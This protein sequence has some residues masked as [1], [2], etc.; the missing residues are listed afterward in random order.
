MKTNQL[1]QLTDARRLARLEPPTGKVRMVLDTDTYNEIDDQFAL[2]YAL[3]S[4]E[5]VQCEAVYAAPFHNDRSSGP[6]DGMEKSY[7]EIGRVLERLGKTPAG[8]AFKGAT[9]WLGSV[10]KPVRSPAV[11]NLIARAKAAGDEPLYVVAIAAITNVVSAILLAPE[12]ME[13]IVVVWLGGQPQHW[14]RATEFNLEQD[15]LAA[16]VLF[17]CGVPLVHVPCLSVAEQLRTTQAELARFMKGHN[18]IGDYLYQI[19]SDYFPDHFAR[20]KVIWD[21]SAV[22]WLINPAWL[23][24]ALVFSPLLRRDWRDLPHTPGMRREHTWSHD[25]ARHLI[26]EIR[27][28]QRDAIFGDLFRK[29]AQHP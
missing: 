9:H 20:S 22:A 16:R 2:V 23:P 5:R 7:A 14:P 6:A 11:D 21:L 28:V 1:P 13:K 12:I 10:D 24:S 15:V 27:A 4:P 26:R 19:Y 18:T 25:S 8:F 29:I 17:D 3:L